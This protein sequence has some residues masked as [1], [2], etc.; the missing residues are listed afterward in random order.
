MYAL[1]TTVFSSLRRP[2]RAPRVGVAED[3]FFLSVVTLGEIVWGIAQQEG[4]NPAFAQDLQ[5]WIDRTTLLFA[6]RLLPFGPEEALIWRR[7]SDGIGHHGA[8]LQIA[9]TAP[10]RGAIVV[11]GDVAHFEPSCVRIDNPYTA[12][13]PAR[14]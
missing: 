6:D 9:A 10:A 14:N 1:E 11:T 4:R 5:S 3:Q 8:G 13:G 7:L 2:D 12:P